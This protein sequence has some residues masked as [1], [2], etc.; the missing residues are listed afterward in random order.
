M[1][2]GSGS[3]YAK[4][5]E[6]GF[7]V[8]KHLEC[9]LHF[10]RLMRSPV[11]QVC[12]RHEKLAPHGQWEVA[13]CEHAPNYGAQRPPHAFGHTDLLRCVGGRELLDNT[14]LQAVL[15]EPLLG[16]LAA[17]IVAPTNDVAAE[18]NGRQSDEQLKRLNS[19]VLD[20]QQLDGSPL[21]I[22][23]GYHAD[24]IVAAYGHWHEGLHQVPL[25]QL[26]KPVD[27]DVGC[28][29]VRKL[30]NLHHGVNVAVQDTPLECDIS[31]VSLA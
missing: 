20:G 25:A 30:L 1:Y 8:V 2:N 18:G 9:R 6:V 15:P 22:L 26:E 11:L 17:L 27:L 29:G 12:N 28:L 7:F 23:V 16:V 4:V 3:D 14:G 5:R 24:V 13:V 21:G 10:E 19:L 31:A